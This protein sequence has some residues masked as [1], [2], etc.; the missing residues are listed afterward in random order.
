MILPIPDP[1]ATR[2]IHLGL[3]VSPYPAPPRHLRDLPVVPSAVD[4][5]APEGLFASVV[6]VRYGAYE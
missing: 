1:T 6:G 5:R 2:Y 3:P 4:A